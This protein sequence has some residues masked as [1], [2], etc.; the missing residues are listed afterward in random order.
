MEENENEY[1]Y[2][3]DPGAYEASL[4]TSLHLP[5]DAAEQNPYQLTLFL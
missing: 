1:D 4:P 2:G 3:R 5:K